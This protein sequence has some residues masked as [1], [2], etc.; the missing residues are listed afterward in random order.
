MKLENEALLNN[1]TQ[2]KT[3]EQLNSKAT[4]LEGSSKG[5]KEMDRKS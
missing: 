2:M 1:K 5:V 3:Y 4:E